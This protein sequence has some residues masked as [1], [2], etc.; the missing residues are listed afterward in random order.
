MSQVRGCAGFKENSSL[1]M[2]SQPKNEENNGGWVIPCHSSSSL[3]P[4]LITGQVFD[5]KNRG[6]LLL[7]VKI[8]M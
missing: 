6:I 7:E 8:S 3:L 4:D 1:G 5:N 2:K